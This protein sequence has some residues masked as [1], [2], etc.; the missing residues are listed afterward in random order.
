MHL[1]WIPSRPENGTLCGI[2]G[3]FA[4]LGPVADCPLSIARRELGPLT[5][6]PAAELERIL[7]R[8]DAIRDRD[9]SAGREATCPRR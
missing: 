9:R 3:G 1:A 2:A 7:A 5:Q 8:A 4:K 6:L